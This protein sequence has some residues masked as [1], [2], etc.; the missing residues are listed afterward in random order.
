MNAELKAKWVAALR[1]G[2]YKQ[3]VGTLRSDSGKFC[4]LGV[5]CDVA[6]PTK[7]KLRANMIDQTYDGYSVGI[8]ESE[9]RE[10]FGLSMSQAGH[11]MTLNDSGNQSFTKIADYIEK[12]L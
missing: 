12:E 2:N 3:G 11:L 5:L 8:L 4:C 6:D 1:S 9:L 10:E 7:W